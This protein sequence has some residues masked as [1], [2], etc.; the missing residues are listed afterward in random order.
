MKMKE[1]NLD[2]W[3][4][5]KRASSEYNEDENKIHSLFLIFF[6]W[7]IFS[8]AITAIWSF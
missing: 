6:R 1:I 5:M 3:K 8:K 7:Q 2:L 4:H